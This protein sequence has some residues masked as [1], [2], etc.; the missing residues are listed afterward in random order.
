MAFNIQDISAEIAAAGLLRTN[1]FEVTF[2]PPPG[3]TT[4]VAQTG[5]PTSN[6]NSLNGIDKVINLYCERANIPGIAM[7]VA[8][9]RRFGY[10]PM[11]KK[12]F[13]P[14][15]NDA[16]LLFRSDAGGALWKYLQ[17]WFR[18]VLN[19]ENQQGLAATNGVLSQQH[20]FELGYKQDYVTDITINAFNDK[21][22]IAIST[23]LMQAYPIFI[24]DIQLA[25]EDK[26]EYVR[27]PATFT[28]ISWYH[29]DPQPIISSNPAGSAAQSL[30]AGV[31]PL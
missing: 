14:T 22:G 7:D 17:S 30:A 29:V 23:V 15:F 24:G 11:E 1:K 18:L 13:A 12:P 28:F 16:Q 31:I 8:P 25:W 6:F 10:G 4:G 26:N 27:I 19:Y 21:G 2:T 9:I 3:L 5:T 20:P